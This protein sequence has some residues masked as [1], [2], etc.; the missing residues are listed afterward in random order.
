MAPYFLVASW[1]QDV[2][3]DVCDHFSGWSFLRAQ[4][5]ILTDNVKT[6]TCNVTRLSATVQDVSM[7]IT[8][9]DINRQFRVG[10]S[11]PIYTILDVDTSVSPATFTIDEIYGAASANFTQAQVGDFYVTMPPDFNRFIAVLDP[12]NNWQLRYW[13]TEEEINAWDAQRSATGTPRVLASRRLA[14]TAAQSGQ[15]QYELWPY[16]L[17][18]YNYPVYYMKRPVQLTDD[19]VFEGPLAYNGNVIVGGVLAK[20]AAW[21]GLEGKKN[22]YYNLNLAQQKT[23]EYERDIGKIQNRD[24]EIYPTDWETYSWIGRFSWA[25][26]DARFIQTHDVG[27]LGQGSGLGFV[28]GG[29]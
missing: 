4:T 23:L 1:V 9:S 25:P 20:C 12:P 29:F 11:S 17:S 22:P 3:S 14:S 18:Q 13:V 19:T 8:A 7:G 10:S 27:L 16:Q 26:L 15:V 21:P 24:Q 5:Q 2:Y 28:S 6:G